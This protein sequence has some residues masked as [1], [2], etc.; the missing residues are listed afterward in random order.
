M[1]SIYPLHGSIKTAPVIASS[2]PRISLSSCSLTRNHHSAAFWSREFSIFCDLTTLVQYRHDV[3]STFHPLCRQE[4]QNQ[5]VI[6]GY[7]EEG[8][9]T[10]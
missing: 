6:Q 2:S 4:Y 8:N 7:Q 3:F 1:N 10:I 5:Q 9:F